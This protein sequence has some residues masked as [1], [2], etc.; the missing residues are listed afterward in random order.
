MKRVD[1]IQCKQKGRFGIGFSIISQ[2]FLCYL[3]SFS[4][5]AYINKI[6]LH[7][8]CNDKNN[9]VCKCA[10]WIYT[11]K[12]RSDSK[13]DTK[14]TS[15]IKTNVGEVKSIIESLKAFSKLYLERHHPSAIAQYQVKLTISRIIVFN[16]TSFSFLS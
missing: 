7:S 1:I 10:R 12:F 4:T 6:S 14:T 11:L 2:P 8:K 13:T 5:F 16:Y 15:Q 3:F 9:A